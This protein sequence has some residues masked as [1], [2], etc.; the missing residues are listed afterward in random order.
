MDL[1]LHRHERVVA[2]LAGPLGWHALEHLD[3]VDSTN[4]VALERARA[5]VPPG[6]VVVADH[7]RA[8]R[9]RGGRPWL[10]GPGDE[11]SLLVSALVPVPSAH[12][13]LVPLAAGLAAG[14][15]IR[16]TGV[17]PRLKWPND[18]LIDER[19]CAGILVERHQLAGDQS[20]E[21]LVV[22]VGIDLDW[23]GVDRSGEA[24]AWTSLAEE[25]AGSD[26]AAGADVDRGDVLADLLRSMATWL[27]SVPT[28]PFR[29]LATYRDACVTIG[30]E[31]EVGFPDGEQLIGRAVDL[32]PDGRLVVD[33]GGR[34]VALN[35][36]DVRHLPG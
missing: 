20:P 16:R 30:R 1:P 4:D 6:L 5:G 10:D 32:D 3:E 28:D 19:K 26:E 22:G 15:A 31:V 11:A 8:G 25:L 24:A 13:S 7:Q 29:L 12:V 33:T 18:V 21:V 34:T 23:R 17:R 14:D 36:G 35:A 9:G 2:A 27:R